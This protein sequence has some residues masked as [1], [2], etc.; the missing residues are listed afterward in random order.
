M[1]RG[2]S[3][4]LVLLVILLLN[5]DHASAVETLAWNDAGSTTTTTMPPWV[6]PRDRQLLD[7]TVGDMQVDMVVAKDASGHFSTVSEALDAAQPVRGKRYV[8][9]IKRGIYREEVVI[10]KNN[11]A[12]IGDGINETVISVNKSR[13]GGGW[14]SYDTAVVYAKGT[15]L[16]A[17]DL[18]IENTAGREAGAAVALRSDS[19]HSVFY[20]CEFKG[21]EDTLLADSNR[22]FYRECIISGTVDFIYGNAKAVFQ[23]SLLLARAPLKGK[24][25]VITAQ[26]RDGTDGSSGFSFQNCRVTSHEDLNGA[27]TYLGRPWRNH[28][29]VVFMQSFLDGIVHPSG[30]VPWDKADGNVPPTVYYGEFANTGP[31]ANLS[32]RVPWLHVMDAGQAEHYT[33]KRFI[34]GDEWLNATGVAYQPGL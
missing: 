28:S 6:Q 32:K 14:A 12:L 2:S 16:M 11:I 24:H 34:R 20:R 1:G 30:W 3:L 23:E 22:Q 8:I 19:K 33:G 5:N 18:T 27:E 15:M 26:G 13:S 4:V 7:L 31:G 17:R 21:Y 29:H 10:R 25:N 9:Y